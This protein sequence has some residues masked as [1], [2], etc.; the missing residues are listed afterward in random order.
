MSYE[1]DPDWQAFVRHVREDTIKK[2]DSS[3]FVMSLVPTGEP[4]V[5][6]AVELGLSI[7]LDKPIIAVMQPGAR[8]PAKLER[9]VDRL[10]EVDVDTE[11]GQRQLAETIREVLQDQ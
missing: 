11:A 10:V 6:F 2:I 7:M 3:A 4:D 8:V 5:K 9:V 1:N